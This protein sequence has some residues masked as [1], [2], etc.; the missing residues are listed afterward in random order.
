MQSPSPMM[1][2]PMTMDRRR[3]VGILIFLGLLLLFV[4]AV[5]TDSSRATPVPGESQA[6]LAARADRGLVLGPAFAHAGMFLFIVGLLG[7]AVYFEDLDVFAR[8]FLM[9]LAF[10]SVLLI[11]AGSTTIF[12][13]P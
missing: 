7:A 6:D 13:V 4:G 8:L 11:L 1:G 9:I 2:G 3:I 12:G 5:L 10:I